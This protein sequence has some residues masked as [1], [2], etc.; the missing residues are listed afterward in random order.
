MLAQQ[1][2]KN[3]SQ[4]GKKELKRKIDTLTW[5]L[6]KKSKEQEE[7]LQKN[8]NLQEALQRAVNSS[9]TGGLVGVQHSLN[10]V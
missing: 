5:K 4:E 1:M 10:Q 3:A 2:A 8:R 6:N 9:G 7:L